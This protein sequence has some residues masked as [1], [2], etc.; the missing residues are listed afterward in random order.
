MLISKDEIKKYLSQV[1]PVPEPA[2]NTLN[3]LKK[4]ELK[5]AAL[6]A[7]K[8]FVLKKQIEDVVNSAHFSLPNKVEN[9]VQLFT[10][11]GIEMAKS[12]VYSYIVS[13]LEP[14]KWK[15]FNINFKDFQAEFLSIY[16]K[17]VL[18]EFGKETYKKYSE[19]GAII[20]VSVCVCDMLLGEKKEKLD[21]ILKSTP[22]EIGTLIKR[23]TGTTLF[24]IA[25]MIG[26]IW[27]LDKQKCEIIKNSECLECNNE[28]SALTH[29][30]FFYLVS[31]PQ[32]IDLNSL[33]EFNPKCI[34]FV[35]KTYKRILDGN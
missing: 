34:D 11:I 16:E 17:Y 6:E 20:P 8:D 2:L 30:L 24:E 21:L 32:F 19:I 27:E 3:H 26:E 23:M 18:L 4:G 25:A 5:E 12:L 22:I 35:P 14:K 9:T 28:I 7:E 29:L 31:K 1:P 13:L 33:I 10:L 15:I